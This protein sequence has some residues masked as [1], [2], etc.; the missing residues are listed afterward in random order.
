[1]NLHFF[2]WLAA[3]LIYQSFGYL[4]LQE[5]NEFKVQER[6]R[7][8]VQAL[9]TPDLFVLVTNHKDASAGCRARTCLSTR[10]TGQIGSSVRS[11][12]RPIA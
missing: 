8:I 12:V 5:Q 2:E 6:K 4:S 11:R 9:L 3:V 1:M 7:A 10:R